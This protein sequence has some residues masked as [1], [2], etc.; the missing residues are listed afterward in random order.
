M[1][2]LLESGSS[3]EAAAEGVG[4]AA[5]RCGRLGRISPRQSTATR[6]VMREGP[7]VYIIWC[8]IETLASLKLFMH[9]GSVM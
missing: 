6:T 5:S 9:N 3:H 2:G 1:G 7:R 4:A 8:V